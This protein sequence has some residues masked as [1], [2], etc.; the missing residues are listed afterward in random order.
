MPGLFL[1]NKIFFPASPGHHFYHH[2][3]FDDSKKIHHAFHWPSNEIVTKK[4]FKYFCKKKFSIF[5]TC[6]LC[7]FYMTSKNI[8]PGFC[9]GFSFLIK[10]FSR[11]RRDITFIITLFLTT[12]KK[13]IMYFTDLQT[14]L[15]LKTFKYFCKKKFS[16]FFTCFL[17][18]FYMTWK[19]IGPAFAG[20]FPF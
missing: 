18:H 13:C 15:S 1:S 16:K 14:T 9:R 5:F 17:C 3:F 2:T 6:F 4:T 19:N 7:H 11:L 10:F 20:A 12:Q 8:G